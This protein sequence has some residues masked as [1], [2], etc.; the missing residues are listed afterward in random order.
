MA[1]DPGILTE[2]MPPVV[3]LG[4]LDGNYFT[5]TGMRALANAPFPKTFKVTKAAMAEFPAPNDQSV[6]YAVLQF[7]MAQLTHC[8]PIHGLQSC[9]FSWALYK[10]DLLILSKSCLLKDC[11]KVTFLCSRRDLFT[12]S[13]TVM[14]RIQLWLFLPLEVQM[15]GPFLFQIQF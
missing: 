13:T 14:Q 11:I 8:T 6:S 10:L 4:P 9:L 3:W 12:F 7:L 1:G 15:H 2:F 5:F